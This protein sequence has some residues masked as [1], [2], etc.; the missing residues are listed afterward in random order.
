MVSGFAAGGARRARAMAAAEGEPEASE[1]GG[2]RTS[3]DIMRSTMTDDLRFAVLIGLVEVGQMEDKE[4][5]NTVLHLLVGG[6]FD[7]E[8]NFVVQDANNILHMLE[9]MDHCSVKLQAEL[10][11]VF[12]CILRKSMRNMQAC[13]ESGRHAGA[14]V[15]AELSDITPEALQTSGDPSRK[16]TR[17]APMARCY[18]NCDLLVELLGTLATYNV[19]VSQLKLLVG[20]MKADGDGW[21]RHSSKLL[22]VLRQMPQR[23]C[24]D[25]FF[26]FPGKTNSWFRLDPVNSV[27]IER[28]KPYLYSFKTSKGVGYS[29]HFVGSC[30]VLTAM[31]IKGKGF[32]HCVKY[33][34]QPRRW[35]MIAIVYIYNR[36]SKSEIKVFVNGQLASSTEM[37]WFVSPGSEVRADLT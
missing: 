2:I 10:W 37:G 8:L 34:F 36:W 26:M 23:N 14:V 18:P 28:E 33:E 35:Y 9:V 25:T 31:K 17:L 5:V 1:Q 22:S 29:A 13:V 4:I 30:L 11:S 6:E 7:M 27:N 21:P 20:S 16:P 32:Q 19:T 15:V 3:S 24:P 12:T